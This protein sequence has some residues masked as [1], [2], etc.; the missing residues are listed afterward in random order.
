[1]AKANSTLKEIGSITA[2]TIADKL[3]ETAGILAAIHEMAG[4]LTAGELRDHTSAYIA[5]AAMAKS[6]VRTLDVCSEALG[7]EPTCLLDDANFLEKSPVRK[8]KV[9]TEEP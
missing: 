7:G 1:M 2:K 5:I 9:V 4:A 8:L 3:N 6:A